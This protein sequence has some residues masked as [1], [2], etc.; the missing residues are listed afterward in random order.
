[1][2]LI[3]HAADA[4][5]LR[6]ALADAVVDGAMEAASL[7]IEQ[8]LPEALVPLRPVLGDSVLDIDALMA[9]LES[10][11]VDLGLVMTEVKAT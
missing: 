4:Q 5:E 2:V 1:M 9:S 3:I 6:H 11:G 10:L 7:L 8:L